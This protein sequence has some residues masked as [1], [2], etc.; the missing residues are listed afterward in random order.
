MLDVRVF[1]SRR[2]TAASVAIALIF[3]ALF[4]TMFVFTQ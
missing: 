1:G 4:G 3:F 2:F